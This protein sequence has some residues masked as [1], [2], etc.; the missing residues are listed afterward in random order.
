MNIESRLKQYRRAKHKLAWEKLHRPHSWNAE[1]RHIIT[2]VNKLCQ[3]D[4]KRKMLLTVVEEM[5][6][7]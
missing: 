5:N 2:I 4:K 3:N 7:Q 1:R 6:N